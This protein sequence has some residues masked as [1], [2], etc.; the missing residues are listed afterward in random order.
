MQNKPRNYAQG[1]KFKADDS[2]DTMKDVLSSMQKEKRNMTLQMN[3]NDRCRSP[4]ACATHGT[5]RRAKRCENP[6]LTGYA[7][8]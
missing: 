5:A 3:Q 4:D 1:S 6:I 7:I 2:F 8:Q